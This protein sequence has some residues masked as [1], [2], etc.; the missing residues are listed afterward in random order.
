MQRV[1]RLCAGLRV[2]GPHAVWNVTWTYE[3]PSGGVAALRRLERVA[4]TSCR[5]NVVKV[6]SAPRE[7]Q[8]IDWFL[9]TTHR[10]FH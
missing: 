8:L 4:K 5:R 9:S 3:L 2:C 6:F 7:N 10:G 1:G